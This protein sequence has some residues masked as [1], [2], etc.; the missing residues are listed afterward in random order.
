MN[1][2]II[3]AFVVVIVLL[4]VSSILGIQSTGQT[5][6]R[7][8][9]LF[10]GVITNVKVSPSNLS[11]A[12]VYDNNCVDIGNGLTECDGGIKTDTYGVLNFHYKHNMATQPCISPGDGLRIEILD[13][14]G[15]ANVI[16]D[17]MGGHHS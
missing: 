11:G 16:R 14:N 12:G 3:F 5:I 13:S 15:N 17:F 2:I 1:K 4:A 6:A 10:R 7:P 9:D 8:R